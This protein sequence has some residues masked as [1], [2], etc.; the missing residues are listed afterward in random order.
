M[1]EMARENYGDVEIA[2]A[3]FIDWQYFRNPAGKAV[4]YLA[5]D[6][7]NDELAGQ[8][9]IIPVQIKLSDRVYLAGNSQD[10]LTRKKY[11]GQKIFKT[12]AGVTYDAC[13]QSGYGAVLLF[14]NENSRGGFLKYL[15]AKSI[16]RFPILC[17]LNHTVRRRRREESAV[18]QI[19]REQVKLFDAFWERARD[20]Y[21]NL[22]VRDARY[23]EWRYFEVPLREYGVFG[24]VE[25]G[26]LEGYI[27]GVIKK[28]ERGRLGVVTDMLV[29]ERCEEGAA[30][31][32]VYAI[33]R[34]FREKGAALS[35]AYFP[36]TSREYRI[37]QSCLYLKVPRRL[38][39]RRFE[40]M[41]SQFEGSSFLDERN[42]YDAARWFTTIGDYLLV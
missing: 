37:L 36:E 41:A 16:Y 31:A 8:Y 1:L 21:E 39:P 28:T 18:F 24:I 13:A 9:I 30:R 29:T 27:T 11:R 22:L 42:G 4:I 6:A 12:L 14:P 15:N 19:T 20:R 17:S 32:L 40:V 26:A 7:D 33:K 25:N 5:Y 34:F 38:E 23:I 10:T 3:E 35:L 2:R